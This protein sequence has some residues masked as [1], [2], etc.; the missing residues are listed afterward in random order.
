MSFADGDGVAV[1]RYCLDGSGLLPGPVCACRGSAGLVHARCLV[2]LAT[3]RWPKLTLWRT[4]PICG[5]DY[6]GAAR[7]A[8]AQAIY[9]RV[10]WR[11]VQRACWRLRDWAIQNLACA[12][13]EVGKHDQA[14]QQAE[15]SIASF[16][17]RRK[18][19]HPRALRI[20]TVLAS[21]LRE[22]GRYGDAV[23]LQRHILALQRRL[24]GSEHPDA[25]SSSNN[26]ASSL[27]LL[28]GVASVPV[29]LIMLCLWIR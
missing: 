12:L 25:I 6:V 24:L 11:P 19:H 26:L 21:S 9:S 28:G 10:R 17:K 23:R 27:S 22:L 20:S 2:D 18:A 7:L 5:Q 15:K 16:K 14:A 4:C 3:S 29:V 8:L 13:Q 1:C